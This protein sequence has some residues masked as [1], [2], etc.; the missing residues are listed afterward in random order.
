MNPFKPQFEIT[1]VLLERIKRI[2]VLVHELNKQAVSSIALSQLQTEAAAVSTFASTSIEGNPLPMTEVKRLLKQRPMRLRQSEQEVVNYNQVLM[3]L[4]DQLD[5]PLTESLLLEIH[6]GVTDGLL[7]THQSGQFRLEPVVVNNPRTG[8]IVYLPPDHGDVAPLVEALLAYVQTNRTAMD[9]LL[10]AG[11]FHKQ[12]VVIHPFVDGNGRT[13]RLATKILLAG[14]GLNL[15]NLFSFENYYNQNVTR[16][17]QQV[18]VLGNYYDWAG[19]LDFTPWL[20]YF[21]EG[22][23]DELLRVQKT[24]ERNQATPVTTLKPHHRQIL[25]YLDEHGFITDRDYA[26]LTDRAKATRT[27]DFNQMIS[28]GLIRREGKGRSIYYRRV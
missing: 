13:T 16:Y 17:F 26:R 18:G 1:A 15:F 2:A 24:I 6:R 28:L 12:F 10:L 5:A 22:I 23:L 11:I 25:A 4:N 27:K 3:S 14:L 19:T 9:P 8:E 21:V 20:T 7:P